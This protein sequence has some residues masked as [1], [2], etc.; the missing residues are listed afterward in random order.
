MS[1]IL[2]RVQS[3]SALALAGAFIV[4][5]GGC[6][7]SQ[8]K[9]PLAERSPKSYSIHGKNVVDDYHW[10]KDRANPKVIAY[11]EA[12][13]AYTEGT[14]R[15]TEALQAK[16]FTEMKGRLKETDLSV[17]YRIDDYYYYSRTFEGKQYNVHCR[18]R[19]SLDAKEEVLLDQNDLAAG[20][21][22]FRLGVYRVS[23][24]HKLLAYSTD[25]DGSE[26]FNLRVKDLDSGKLLKD[27]IRNT[28]YSVAWGNDD[29]TI[30]YTVLDSAKRP[31][32]VFRHVLGS[33][34]ATDQLV[35]HET[36]E[37]F[38][39][40]LSKTRSGK[41]ILIQS[42]SMTTKEWRF[43]EADKP[44][45]D[46]RIVQPRIQGLEYSVE[47]HGDQFYIVANDNAR[48]FKLVRAP[49]SSPDKANWT[50]VIPHR[51]EVKIEGVEAFAEHLVISERSGGLTNLRVRGV[52]DSVEHLIAF[53]E[54]VY[55]VAAVDNEDFK[56][57]TLRFSYTSLVTPRSVFDYDMKARTRQMM[58]Q[59]EV[60][61][62]YDPTK[63]ES[64]RLHA[65][66]A[67]GTNV[68]ISLV[69]HKGL[70]L[71]GRNPMLL[72]GYGSYGMSMDPRFI[73][74]RLS[75][76]DRGF[77]YAI[78]HIRGG[79]EMGRPWYEDGKLMKK[80]NTFE[81]FIASAEHLIQLGYTSPQRLAI[82]GG[83]AGGLLMG[84]V[85][86]MRPDLFRAVVAHV[87][88]VDVMNTMLDPSIPL[89][90]IEYE[91][92]GNPNQRDAYDYMLSYSPYDNVEA[93]SYPDILITAGLNDPRVGYWEPAK[94]AAKLRA[95]KTDSNRLL[96]K[97]NMGAGHGGASGRYDYLKEIAFVY[98]F[99]LDSMGL[100][101]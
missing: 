57:S 53:P 8:L 6:T 94:W 28:Y 65:K 72:Y 71:D 63:Y 43:V 20:Q 82:Q 74:Y 59:E 90:V 86:N 12:E 95:T 84:A 5:V 11:L 46:W 22:Y 10:L 77:V 14:M 40:D 100:A 91:E 54:P 83:S 32:K 75:L 56:T 21:E 60:L 98:A 31:Y 25:T 34:S 89:T 92:W 16:L 42:H 17:P 13:N 27:E 2:L 85:T 76:L 52:A 7:S 41:Y 26:A 70:K 58:K 93:K 97:T 35:Y 15:P 73:A 64:A 3:R 24:S 30:F 9:P 67:D 36:D 66:A 39:V 78:A 51:P 81:D 101:E 80:R 47:H 38:H 96:L 18:K 79:G 19:G 55:T 99:V 45:G 29:Q 48:N 1:T 50:D 87:P 33:D 4:T 61:G 23:P 68:P 69:H 49:V 44:L 37:G 62:G 88:F